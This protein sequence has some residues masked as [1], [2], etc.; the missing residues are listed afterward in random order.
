MPEKYVVISVGCTECGWSSFPEVIL[1]T[2]SFREACDLAKEVG[3]SSGRQGD[4]FVVRSDGVIVGSFSG[5]VDA[6]D[7]DGWVEKPDG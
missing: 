6:D 3:V 4:A 2:S 7:D 1:S 5:D